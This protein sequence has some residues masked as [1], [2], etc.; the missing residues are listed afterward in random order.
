VE[1]LVLATYYT[2]FDHDDWWSG[3][4]SDTP[5]IPYNSDDSE[6]MARHISQAQGAGIDAFVVAWLGPG[7]R[8]DH[9]FRRLLDLAAARGFRVAVSMQ[10]Q[11]IP[12]QSRDAVTQGM[13]HIIGSYGQHPAYLKHRGKPVIFFTDMPRVPLAGG[14]TPQQAWGSIRQQVDPNRQTIWIA[15]GLETSY[16]EVFD[17]LYVIKIDHR[18]FPHDYVKMPRWGANAR[19]YAAQLGFSRLWVASIMPGWNDTAASGHQSDFRSPSPPFARDREDGA[20]YR[21]TFDYAIASAP[22]WL[23]V[24]SFNEWAEGTQIEPSTSYGDKYLNITKELSV[25][26]KGH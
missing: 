3:L 20:Y 25:R 22:D 8:T 26:F 1:R 15:E 18:D 14:E 6:A 24:Q 5:V 19:A 2:W 9:N 10:M 13:A 11:I 23:F 4:F 17:G 12:G 16:L 21:R 7:N